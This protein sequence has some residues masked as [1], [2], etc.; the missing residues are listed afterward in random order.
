[1]KAHARDEEGTV[2]ETLDVDAITDEE[3][4]AEALAADPDTEV[5]PDA[6]PLAAVLGE[7]AGGPLPAWYMPAAMGR[8]R[9]F[10]GWHRVPVAA[11]ILAL[12]VINMAG[13]CNTYGQLGFG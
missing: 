2:P 8:P 5:A 11:V 10:T 4:S 1:V 13:L 6:V 9:T 7:R 3:L 12:L